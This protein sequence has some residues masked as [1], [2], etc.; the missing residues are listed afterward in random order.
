MTRRADAIF[1]EV[2]YFKQQRLTAL[3]PA[4]ALFMIAFFAYA[5]YEQFVMGRPFG[6]EPMSDTGLGVIGPF[7]ILLGVL[8]LWLYISGKLVTEVRPDGVYVL[9]HPLH[10]SP[11]HFPVPTIE[12]SE[13]M[14]YR[15][16]RDFGGW[17]IRH[18]RKGRAYNVYGNRGAYL[19][20]I[21]G[22]RVLI[23]SQK[24]DILADSI[25]SL[26]DEAQRGG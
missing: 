11:R 2:Q 18:G 9:F 14:T 24:A 22:K 21:D 1:Y 3:L 23:G 17:G 25:Q 7:Y 20:L 12:K 19:T 5:M 13:T 6:D 4:A 16:I 8:F 26:I 10:R 15:P